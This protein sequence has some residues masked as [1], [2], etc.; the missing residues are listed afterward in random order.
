M[1]VGTTSR[2]TTS[3][4]IVA[5]ETSSRAGSVALALGAE[6]VA[7]SRFSAPLRHS[8]EVFPAIHGL[9]NRV[10]RKPS[11]I[12]HVYISFGPGS[13]SGL[14]IA[15]TLAK[16]MNLANGARIVA[17]DTLD[18]VAANVVGLSGAGLQ[19]IAGHQPPDV[20]CQRLAA[21]L[22]AKRGR[23]FIAVYERQ[24][25][26]EPQARQTGVWKKL[27][28]DSLMTIAEFLTRFVGGQGPIWLLGD[29]L[30]Y[31]QGDFQADGVRFF[32][33]TYW[34]PQARNVHALGWQMALRG[35]FADP[36]T[37][38]PN[39]LRRPDITVKSR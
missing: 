37:L 23:F 16:T 14:R 12:E 27:L 20:N 31:Y 29:G 15:T 1:V 18:V 22:D 4:L 6:L 9:L 26:D 39:Y 34:S 28:P 38:T 10:G 17:V 5:V 35:Q 7:E 30:V 33:Q 36:L 32:E 8:A 3:P 11:Q 2:I 21:V 25:D 24:A 13:F 19:P